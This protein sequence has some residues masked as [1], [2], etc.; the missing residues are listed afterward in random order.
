MT[1]VVSLNIPEGVMFTDYIKRLKN[2]RCFHEED[3]IGEF[4]TINFFC[5]ISDKMSIAYGD[6]PKK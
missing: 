5:S 1:P 2:N 6:V 4:N 3:H